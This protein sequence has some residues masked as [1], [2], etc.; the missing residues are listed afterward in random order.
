MSDLDNLVSMGFDKERSEI[1]LKRAGNLPNAIDWL[2]KNQDTP[3]DELQQE[4]GPSATTDSSDL[5]EGE[6]AQSLVCNDCQRQLRSTMQA[7][8]HAEKTGHTNFSEST[9]EIAP[10]TEEQK[11]EKLEMLKAR[12]DAKRAEQE[13]TE[14]AERKRNEEIKRKSTKEQ[15]D[16]KEQLEQKERI[17]EAEAK[18]REKQADIDAKKRI[19]AKIA[20]DKAERKRKADADK[21]ARVGQ[22]FPP[23]P[24]AESLPAGAPVPKATAETT[25]PKPASEYT[26]T[27]LRLQTSNGNYQGSFK[28]DVTLAEV[29]QA[30]SSDKGV[31]V[32]AIQ[33]NF[34]KK[35]F[36]Q[37][38][39]GM[40][41]KEAGL[42]P[43][44]ALMV[45]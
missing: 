17:K 7:E 29:A 25:K 9:Q 11:A 13:Q 3:L 37:V 6:V 5:K 30:V 28:V 34:P 27:R 42:V 33:Q 12:R 31:E 4:S 38:D 32:N 39:W 35:T 44:A 18:K 16:A 36:E 41:L 43:S 21:A 8:A 24:L 23:S 14:K 19:Q 10:L 1:A 26:E 45:K 20:E 15:Q 40:T 2:D 22:T